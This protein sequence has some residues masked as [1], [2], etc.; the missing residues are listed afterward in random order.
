MELNQPNPRIRVRSLQHK[1]SNF[2]GLVLASPLNHLS[3]PQWQIAQNSRYTIRRSS[4]RQNAPP[5]DAVGNNRIRFSGDK[6]SQHCQ[7]PQGEHF[8]C[9]PALYGACLEGARVAGGVGIKW[10]GVWWG[11]RWGGLKIIEKKRIQGI[12]CQL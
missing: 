7:W 9:H 4:H 1:A 2:K 3:R 6:G 10:G 8:L 12:S 5:N 11:I